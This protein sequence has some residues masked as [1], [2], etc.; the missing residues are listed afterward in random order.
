MRNYYVQR[1]CSPTRAALMCVCSTGVVCVPGWEE[2]MYSW[3]VFYWCRTGRYNI[4]MG[5]ASGVMKPL[6]PYCLPL[7]E[8]LLPQ[9][10]DPLGFVS[11]AVGKWHLGYYDWSCT[12]TH[13]GFSSYYGYYTGG[14]NYY[15]HVSFGGGL[16]FRLDPVPNTT[17]AGTQM[18]AA[19]SANDGKDGSQ[20][21]YSTI[22][23][24]GR[25]VELVRAHDFSERGLFLYLPFQAVIYSFPA[26]YDGFLMTRPPPLELASSLGVTRQPQQACSCAR[27][28]TD[29]PRAG[30]FTGPGARPLQEPVQLYARAAQRACRDAH[31]PGRR[32]RQRLR[33]AAACGGV[34]GKPRC[35]HQRQRGGD[36]CLRWRDWGSKLALARRKMQCVGGERFRVHKRRAV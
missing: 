7:N 16:D 31:L 33:G 19:E 2:L 11:H 26:S 29:M 30:T 8:T 17:A 13:R 12:P 23:Y 3:C 22:L 1:A 21:G 14:E 10:L 5:F 36:A 9:Y 18:L 6:K 4:R 34:E 24:A 25:A 35:V 28:L 32:G 20:A 27:L 15:T